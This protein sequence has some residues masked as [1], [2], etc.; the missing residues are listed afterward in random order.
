MPD[1]VILVAVIVLIIDIIIAVEFQRIAEAKG[2]Y[3]EKY[4]VLCFLLGLPGWLMVIALPDREQIWVN[5][6]DD[7]YDEEIPDL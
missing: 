6:P 4:G 3:S 2:H 5:Q 1:W 7:E